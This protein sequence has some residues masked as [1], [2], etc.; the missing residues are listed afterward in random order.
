M[1]AIIDYGMGNIHSVQKA[2]EYLGGEA[3]VTNRGDEIK[4]CAR[5]VLPGVGAFDD[6]IAVSNM[7]PDIFGPDDEH[8]FVNNVPPYDIQYRCLVSKQTENLLA[9]GATIS[10]DFITYA[11]TR[12]CTPSICT[13][14]AAGTAAALAVKHQTSPKKLDVKGLRDTLRDQGA[15]VTVK[16]VPREVLEEYERNIKQTTYGL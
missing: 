9:A 11:A 14:Q 16:E 5:L 2:V 15:R 13:G 3:L 7:S 6:A 10:V 1:V 12:Y 4:K 8:E